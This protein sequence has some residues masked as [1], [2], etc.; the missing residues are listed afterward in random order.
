MRLP[1]PLVLVLHRFD[2]DA[3]DHADVADREELLL[4]ARAQGGRRPHVGRSDELVHVHE[5]LVPGGGNLDVIADADACFGLEEGG[6]LG[7][8]AQVVGLRPDVHLHITGGPGVGG[9]GGSG[10]D[11]ARADGEDGGLEGSHGSLLIEVG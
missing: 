3:A 7:G 10:G 6:T 11:E 9:E 2:G 5:G 4:D 8:T 1:L